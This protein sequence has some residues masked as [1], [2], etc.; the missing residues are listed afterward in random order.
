MLAHG[1]LGYLEQL[2]REGITVVCSL[3]I[4]S[5][6]RRYGT[7]ILALKDGQLVFEGPAEQLDR[8]RFREIYGEEA[9]DVEV[10]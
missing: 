4:P 2:N 3:H 8:Q 5:W 9:Q 1:I 10:F 7:R 6:A